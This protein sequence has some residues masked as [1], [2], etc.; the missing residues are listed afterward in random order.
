MSLS[1]T[2]AFPNFRFG[3][4]AISI[5]SAYEAKFFLSSYKIYPFKYTILKFKIARRKIA[6]FASAQSCATLP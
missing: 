6:D 5:Y 3:H 1:M 4:R 2:S